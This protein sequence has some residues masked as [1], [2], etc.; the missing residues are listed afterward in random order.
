MLGGGKCLTIMSL[1]D[2]LS[3]VLCVL[4]NII[5]LVHIPKGTKKNPYSAKYSRLQKKRLGI[6]SA[7][8][9]MTAFCIEDFRSIIIISMFI[10]SIFLI[11]ELIHRFQ[12]VE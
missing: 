12:E 5:F 10:V 6:T 7:L 11:P 8:L 2:S 9:S 1:N 4:T 3:I